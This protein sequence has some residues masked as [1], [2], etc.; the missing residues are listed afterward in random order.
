VRLEISVHD[1]VVRITYQ[2]MY[3]L[4]V[5]MAAMGSVEEMVDEK[6]AL[7]LEAEGS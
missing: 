7:S 2:P 1:V 5:N 6:S 4:R 3:L